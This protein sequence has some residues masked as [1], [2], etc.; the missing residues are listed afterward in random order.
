[1]KRLV[2]LMLICLLALTGC[3]NDKEPSEQIVGNLKTYYALPDG[4]WQADGYTYQYRLEIRGRLH[5]AAADSVFVYLSN[6]EEITFE[7]AW[8]AAG[9]SSNT[10][11]YFAAEDAVLVEMKTVTDCS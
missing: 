4:T 8:L 9:L 3:G 10:E 11:D 2:V 5:N 7:Q 6:L 1:M